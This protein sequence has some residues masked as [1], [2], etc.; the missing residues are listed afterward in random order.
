MSKLQLAVLHRH[1]LY[2]DSVRYRLRRNGDDQVKIPPKNL[3]EFFEMQS[4]F[5][6]VSVWYALL[7]VVVEGYLE[8][9][10]ED[11]TIN[12]LIADQEKVNSLR[13][14][15]NAI[16]H[17]Q[18]DPFSEKLLGF[19]N[20][21]DTETWVHNLNGSFKSFFERTFDVKHFAETLNAI[22]DKPLGVL[23]LS[24]FIPKG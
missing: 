22:G 23:D 14:F 10:G 19:L 5:L 18:E 4:L 9:K 16:F 1:W 3:N 12:R 7:Y 6:A 15:R 11:E 8:I 17:F 20:M 2:A 21:K 24:S 13:R